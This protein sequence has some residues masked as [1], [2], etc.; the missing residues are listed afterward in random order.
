[1]QSVE[2][3]ALQFMFDC[4]DEPELL[5][6]QEALREYPERR[7]ALEAASRRPWEQAL[8]GNKKRGGFSK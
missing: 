8:A 6:D 3:A 2:R 4:L 7:K 5:E 1:L